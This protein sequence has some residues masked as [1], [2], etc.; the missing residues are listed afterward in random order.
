M[1][2][3]K[4]RIRQATKTMADFLRLVLCFS[5]KK[6]NVITIGRAQKQAMDRIKNTVTRVFKTAYHPCHQS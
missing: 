2:K 5:L 1:K 4:L 3:T 6:K